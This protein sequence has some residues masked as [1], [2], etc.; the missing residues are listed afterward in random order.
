M[1]LITSASCKFAEDIFI[2]ISVLSA[3]SRLDSECWISLSWEYRR[4]VLAGE[5]HVIWSGAANATVASGSRKLPQSLP[6][7]C[8][9]VGGGET[10]VV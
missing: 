2:T 10:E 5:I 7:I 8:K 4:S 9:H 1:V 3:Q 6:N